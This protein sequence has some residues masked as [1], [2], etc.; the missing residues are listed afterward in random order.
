MWKWL[1]TQETRRIRLQ[2]KTS[3]EDEKQGILASNRKMTLQCWEEES[4]GIEIRS[5]SVI[6]SDAAQEP[7][8]DSNMCRAITREAVGA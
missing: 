4:D 3:E 5:R 2:M 1:M 6:I 7:G 8:C